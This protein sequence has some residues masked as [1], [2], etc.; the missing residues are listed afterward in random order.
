MTSYI[1]KAIIAEDVAEPRVVVV[2][3]TLLPPGD[4]P[5]EGPPPPEK[6]R[7]EPGSCQHQQPRKYYVDSNW[8]QHDSGER[9][10]RFAK[11]VEVNEVVE[12]A[13]RC[14]TGQ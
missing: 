5:L 6:S 13:S 4:D 8:K 10:V 14:S 2:K 12:P 1:S 7:S 9:R 3:L 11:Y